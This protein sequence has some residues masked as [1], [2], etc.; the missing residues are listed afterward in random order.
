MVNPIKILLKW[1]WSNFAHLSPVWRTHTRDLNTHMRFRLGCLPK[2]P[3]NGVIF[4]TVCT[5][6]LCTYAAWR[7]AADQ[8]LAGSL[9]PWRKARVVTAR[10]WFHFS[11]LPFCDALSAPVG[12][13][14][15]RVASK[16]FVWKVVLGASSPPW[17][18]RITP[19]SGEPCIARNACTRSMGGYFDFRR[20][21]HTYLD[22]SSTIIRYKEYSTKHSTTRVIPSLG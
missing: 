14:M 9:A 19:P 6:R 8:F 5:C 20:N 11:A 13:T 18:V 15:Y 12:S 22:D 17:L 3:L 4:V 10:A 16:N 1:W 2:H 21:T 7:R